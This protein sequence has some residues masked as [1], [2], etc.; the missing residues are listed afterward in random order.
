[1]DK[2]PVAL[3]T[4]ASTGLGAEF[5]RLFAHDGYDVVLVARNVG[6]LEALAERLR[7]AHKI[8]AHVVAEDLAKPAAAGRVWDRVQA[9]GLTIE[10]LVNNAGFGSAGAF[11]DLPAAAEVEMVE[12]NCV[13]LLELTH[14]FGE[15]MRKRGHGR[16]LNIAST[17]AFQAGPYMATY[18]AS[19]AFVLSFSEA[20]AY[21][22]RPHGV[23]VT[24]HCPGA[25]ATEFA[26]RAGNNKSKLFQ[27][28]GVAKA[29]A[30][31]A[32]AYKAMMQGKGIAIHG[33]MNWLGV[34]AIRFLPRSVVH[35]IAAALNQP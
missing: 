22:L 14:R 12:L 13:T 30:V 1:M 19:K 35:R 27:R 4:G 29:D 26:G 24:C 16:I 20:L 21:E 9:L 2:K 32:H 8:N 25:T 5:A 7:G 17:A 18:Y 33:F 3:I 31:A 10:C 34:Q 28:P 23:T 15:A 11:F 6:R